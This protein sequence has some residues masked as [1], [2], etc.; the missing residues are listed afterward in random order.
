MDYSDA[1]KWLQDHGVEN[2]EEHRPFQIGDDISEKPERFMTDTIAQVFHCYN[3][4]ELASVFQPIM[5]NRF[6]AGIKSF[7]MS[8]CA[9]NRELTESVDLL[10][11]GVGEI[12]GG[13]MRIWKVLIRLSPKYFSLRHF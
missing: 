10:M 8:R 3:F 2:E 7:Y 13:S 6:P 11:P 4:S 5:L 12:V 9:D 1:I